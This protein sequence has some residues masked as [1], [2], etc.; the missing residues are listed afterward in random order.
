M[1]FTQTIRLPRYLAL[2]RAGKSMPAKI[3]M[4]AITTNNSINV[5]AFRHERFGRITGMG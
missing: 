4:I 2:A 5:N 3:A 1:L